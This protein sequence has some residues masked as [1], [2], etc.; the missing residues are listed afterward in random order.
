MQSPTAHLH[1][2]LALERTRIL[3]VCPALPEIPEIASSNEE[4]SHYSAACPEGAGSK[5]PPVD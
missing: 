2:N 3:L 1:T 5:P 4:G